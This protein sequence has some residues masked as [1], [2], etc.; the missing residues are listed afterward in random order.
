MCI[1]HNIRKIARSIQQTGISVKEKLKKRVIWTSCIL[2]PDA[3][4]KDLPEYLRPLVKLN[5]RGAFNRF[6]GHSMPNSLYEKHR[7]DRVLKRLK[8][9]GLIK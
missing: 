5:V 3:S 1:A 9:K 4:K 8:R 6:K 2:V 7:Q